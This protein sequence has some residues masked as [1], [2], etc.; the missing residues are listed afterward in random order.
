M[1]I[2]PSFYRIKPIVIEKEEFNL[3]RSVFF[4]GNEIE[5]EN[6]TSE[7]EIERSKRLIKKT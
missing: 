2:K 4:I 7:E 5:E 6:S 1:S 3:G